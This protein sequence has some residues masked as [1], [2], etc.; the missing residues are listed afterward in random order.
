MKKLF[1]MTLLLTA[2]FL[3]FSSCSKDDDNGNSLSGTKWATKFADNDYIVIEFVSDSEV[4]GYFTDANFVIVG[5]PSTGKYSMND[6][7]ITF[8]NFIINYAGIAKYKYSEA[9]ISGS[10]LRTSYQWK[11]NSSNDWGSISTDN[12]QKQ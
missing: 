4:E 5:N 1:S 6:N 9:T 7:K 11:Y 12:F 8:N 10:I 2:M 3:T